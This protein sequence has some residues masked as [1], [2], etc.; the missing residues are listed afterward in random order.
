V[1][2]VL[3]PHAAEAERDTDVIARIVSTARTFF[4]TSSESN[5]VDCVALP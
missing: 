2:D 3:E 5:L 1:R 4:M